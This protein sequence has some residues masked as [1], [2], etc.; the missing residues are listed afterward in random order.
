LWLLAAW[1]RRVSF[2]PDIATYSSLSMVGSRAYA[3]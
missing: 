3:S 2:A 1:A